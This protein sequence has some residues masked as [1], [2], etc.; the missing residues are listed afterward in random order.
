MH[1]LISFSIYIYLNNPLL[2]LDDRTSTGIAHA[3]RIT[4][5]KSGD[6]LKDMLKEN[7]LTCEKVGTAKIYFV[8]T[9][10]GLQ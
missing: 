6:V 7:L 5:D 8:K 1:N 10:D 9:G 2:A 3:M 4:K